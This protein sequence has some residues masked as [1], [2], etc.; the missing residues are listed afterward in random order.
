MPV[1][2]IDLKRFEPDFLDRWLERCRDITANTRFVGGPDVARLEA[3]LAE[4]TGAAAAVGCA[5]GTDAIQLALRA[6]GVSGGDVVLV[7]DATFWATFEAVVNVGARPVTVDID[8]VDLQMDFDRFVEAVERYRPRAAVLVHLYGWGSRRLAD[9][10]AFS[11]A[12]G[13]PLVEDGAQAFGVQWRGESVLRDAYLGTLSFYPAKVLGACGDAG[14]V[15]CATAE[16]AES[17]R[18]LGNHGRT[19]HYGHG[20]VGWNSRLGGFEASFLD[21]SLDYFIPRL[22]SRRAAAERYRERLGP[23]GVQVM[24]P[25]EGYVENA[26]LN[27]CLVEPAWRPAIEAELR[28]RGIGYGNVYPGAMSSQPGAAAHLAGRVGGEHAERLSQSVLN[29]PLFAY[30]REE[31][32]DEVVAAVAATRQVAAPSGA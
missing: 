18:C 6:A 5:N 25:P 8:P 4:A 31:E 26:Y 11:R 14:A 20:F 7:P 27:V 15:C 29:L 12:R 1:P 3:R 32:I 17:V 10:R 21:L 9:F 2:F 22:A 23:L 28:A 19:A 24:S 13:L 30:M 16:L